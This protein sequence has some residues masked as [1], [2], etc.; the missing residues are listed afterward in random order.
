VSYSDWNPPASSVDG[1]HDWVL[2]SAV[3]RHCPRCLAWDCRER[4][5]G[6]YWRFAPF[7]PYGGGS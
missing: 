2:E 3:S 1:A 7:G 5:E 4:E 6:D